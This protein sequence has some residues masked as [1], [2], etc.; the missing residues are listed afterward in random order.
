MVGGERRPRPLNNICDASRGTM[1]FFIPETVVVCCVVCEM[2]IGDAGRLTI[3]WTSRKDKA[4]DGMGCCCTTPGQANKSRALE[5]VLGER[6]G[7][8]RVNG[9]SLVTLGIYRGGMVCI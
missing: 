4:G 6:G 3:D 2:R 9:E 7:K 8:I 1:A 5:V